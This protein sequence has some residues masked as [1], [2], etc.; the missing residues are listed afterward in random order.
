[1]IRATQRDG[2]VFSHMQV[3]ATVGADGVPGTIL[4]PVY[5]NARLESVRALFLLH[6][7]GR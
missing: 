2:E 4:I 3:Q 7:G 1:M 5:K 6:E